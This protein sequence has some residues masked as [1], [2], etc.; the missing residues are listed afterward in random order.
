[1]SSSSLLHEPATPTSSATSQTELPERR[2]SPCRP[3]PPIGHTR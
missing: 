2:R 1:V 3:M